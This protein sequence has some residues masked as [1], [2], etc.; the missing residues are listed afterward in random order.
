MLLRELMAANATIYVHLDYNVG[1]YAKAVLDEIFGADRF[2]NEIIWKRQ[3]AKGDVTQ[4]ARHMGRIHESIYLYSKSEDYCWNVL[5][6]PYDQSYIDAF[7]RHAEIQMAVG[8][9][10]ATR[11]HLGR[12][13]KETHT[14]N[15][16]ALPATTDSLRNECESCTPR[17]G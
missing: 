6:T 17:G 12:P 13:R 9:S 7:Y 4:G 3:S 8:T 16:S 2:V 1:H 10:L 15:S 11:R 5:F 14:T